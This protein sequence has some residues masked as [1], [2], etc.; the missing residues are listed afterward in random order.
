[1]YDLEILMSVK[2]GFLCCSWHETLVLDD[3]HERSPPVFDLEHL[4]HIT[5][6]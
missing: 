3:L 5:E 6:V 2:T 4:V 1:M